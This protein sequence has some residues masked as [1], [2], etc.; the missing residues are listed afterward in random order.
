MAREDN[1]EMLKIIANYA[2]RQ[3]TS[4]GRPSTRV[5][6]RSDAPLRNREDA[7]GPVATLGIVRNQELCFAT[8]S[9]KMHNFAPGQFKRDVIYM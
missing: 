3:L 6:G 5:V 7:R 8:S 4:G 1:I 2:L 9:M